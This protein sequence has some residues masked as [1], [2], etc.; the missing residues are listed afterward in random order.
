MEPTTFWGWFVAP[1]IRFQ[2]EFSFLTPEKFISFSTRRE[3][4]NGIQSPI[5]NSP[6]GVLF[7]A[8]FAPPIS[9]THL[10][11]YSRSAPE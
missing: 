6:N 7:R 10:I 11:S 1:E 2:Q 3:V 5:P 9:H 4:Q 8:T